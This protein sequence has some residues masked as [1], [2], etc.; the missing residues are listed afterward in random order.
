MGKIKK[1]HFNEIIGGSSLGNEELYPITSSEA[2]YRPNGQLIEDSFNNLEEKLSTINQTFDNANIAINYIWI[3]K[4]ASSKEEALTSLNQV[5]EGIPSGWQE[6]SSLELLDGQSIYFSQARIQGTKYL[7]W[8]TGVNLGK[9]WTSPIILGNTTSQIGVDSDGMD[10]IYCRTKEN[11]APTLRT[12][13]VTVENIKK[14]QDTEGIPYNNLTF[15]TTTLSYNAW[16]NHP[17]GVSADYPYEWMAYAAKQDTVWGEYKGPILWAKYGEKGTDGD[18]V[19]YIFSLQKEEITDPSTIINTDI[20]NEFSIV[21]N[22]TQDDFIPNNPIATDPVEQW[23]DNPRNVSEAYPYQYVSIRKKKNGIWEDFSIPTIWAKFGKDGDPGI[24]SGYLLLNNNDTVILDNDTITNTAIQAAANA[25]FSIQ[26]TSGKTDYTVTYYLDNSSTI[27]NILDATIDSTTGIL[28]YTVKAN[29][30]SLPLGVYNAKIKAFVSDIDG[31]DIKPGEEESSNPTKG[32]LLSKQQTIQVKNFS[33]GEVYKLIVEPN[34]IQATSTGYPKNNTTLKVS[35]NKI[36]KNSITTT[37]LQ[38]SPNLDN[39]EDSAGL[40]WVSAGNSDSIYY[41]IFEVTGSRRTI[42]DFNYQDSEDNII[43][44][45]STQLPDYYIVELRKAINN[46]SF[47]VLDSETIN[48]AKSGTNGT[49]IIQ[50]IL[51]NPVDYIL[52]KS[53]GKVYATT[54]ISTKVTLQNGAT[55]ITTISPS[56]ISVDNIGTFTAITTVTNGV[57]TITWNLPVTATLIL[58]KYTPT[59][60]ISYGNKTYSVTFTLIV[61]KGSV[62]YKPVADTSS[63]YFNLNTNGDLSPAYKDLQIYYQE[64]EYVNS[65]LEITKHQNLIDYRLLTLPIG[66]YYKVNIYFTN[67]EDT[68]F[69]NV[70]N[71]YDGTESNNGIITIRPEAILSNDKGFFNTNSNFVGNT[72][73]KI[74]LAFTNSTNSIIYSQLEIPVLRDG[75]EGLTGA[76]VR[77]MGEF[78]KDTVY[79]NQSNSRIS[80]IRYIDVVQYRINDTTLKYYQRNLNTIGYSS[81]S[82]TYGTNESGEVIFGYPKPTNTQYWAE[83]PMQDSVATKLL[84]TENAWTEYLTGKQITCVNESNAITAGINGTASINQPVIYAGSNFINGQEEAEGNIS[85]AKAPLRIFRDGTVKASKFVLSNPTL[86][87]FSKDDLNDND[88]MWLTTYENAKQISGG[89]AKSLDIEDNTPVILMR[90]RKIGAS[91]DSFFVLNPLSLVK[92]NNVMSIEWV[93]IVFD[94]SNPFSLRT[95]GTINLYKGKDSERY[96]QNYNMDTGEYEN[97]YNG[98]YAEISNVVSTAESSVSAFSMFDYCMEN[99]D[100]YYVKYKKVQLYKVISGE[101]N[102]TALTLNL[103]GSVLQGNST[104]T[105]DIY[106]PVDNIYSLTIPTKT[107]N[108]ERRYIKIVYDSSL[109]DLSEDLQNQQNLFYMYLHQ[110]YVIPRAFIGWLSFYDMIKCIDAQIKVFNS[111]KTDNHYSKSD[112]MSMIS[113]SINNYYWEQTGQVD[114]YNLLQDKFGNDI[115]RTLAECIFDNIYVK[116]SDGEPAVIQNSDVTMSIDIENGFQETSSKW[117][118]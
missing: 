109:T 87:I 111:I 86:S 99:Y 66:W 36:D 102:S 83:V 59:I 75:K 12:T 37:N 84:I 117:W 31:S 44:D 29:S 57:I 47:I 5:Y 88:C 98:Y 17:N 107:I 76:V 49:S 52:T 40:D 62:L 46:N 11:I 104:S 23:S 90:Y 39:A 15:N 32:F 113:D 55:P 26:N 6:N 67:G 118:I 93:K 4:A 101:I 58:A 10:Y 71:F 114:M 80:G 19:E 41:K 77:M 3:F 64:E 35:Y 28:S 108:L 22:K 100:D 105:Q 81:T 116:S 94:E 63:V 79:V 73:S 89:S 91:E 48:I 68:G 42:G 70:L 45:T 74:V 16:Y 24:V 61:Q 8:A 25:E 110:N 53:T 21:T 38:Y 34:S 103:Q 2:I 106:I 13:V 69:I 115:F 9:V 78:N 30:N 60:S 54:S 50:A 85:P 1:L 33:S 18:S 65:K 14:L 7:T 51:S 43:I 92:N 27:L 96:Y 72:I 112:R 56:N 97:P 82:D 95:N 20:A